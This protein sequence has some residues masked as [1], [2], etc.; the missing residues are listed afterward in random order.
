MLPAYRFLV[1]YFDIAVNMKFVG[2]RASK[3][4]AVKGGGL[5]KNSAIRPESNQPSAAR[6]RVPVILNI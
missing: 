3:L 4:P 6:V 5:T 1:R 2:Q